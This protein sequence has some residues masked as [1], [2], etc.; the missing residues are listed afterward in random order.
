M[1]DAFDSKSNGETRGGSSPLTGT[2]LLPNSSLENNSNELFLCFDAIAHKQ[3]GATSES[4]SL[5]IK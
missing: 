2:A 1:A 3:G 5:A 4:G